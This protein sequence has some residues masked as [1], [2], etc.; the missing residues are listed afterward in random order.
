MARARRSGSIKAIANQKVEES[1]WGV[2]ESPEFS[3]VQR[4]MLEF[5]AHESDEERWLSIYK[6][7]VEG[8]D[9]PVSRFLLNLIVADEEKHRELIG[10]MVSS[11]KD[12]LASTRPE[13]LAG[14]TGATGKKGQ[15]LLP[16]VE[17]FLEVERQGIREYERLIKSSQGFHHDLFALLCRTMV[18]DSLKHIGI[19]EFLRAKLRRQK[20]SGRGKKK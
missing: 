7:I 18:H 11:L 15:E 9:D 10:R 19:L 13:I 4:L 1:M 20:K 14:R 8:A 17:R 12:D 3:A 5:Q 16:M 6:K 2:P